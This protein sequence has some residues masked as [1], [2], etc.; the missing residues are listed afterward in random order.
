[1]I[2]T[3][4]AKLRTN[5]RRRVFRRCRSGQPDHR[6]QRAGGYG[7][8]ANA[9]KSRL[10]GLGSSTGVDLPVC[11]STDHNRREQK[12]PPIAARLLRNRRTRHYLRPARRR[13]RHGGWGCATH[14][15]LHALKPFKLADLGRLPA[16]VTNTSGLRRIEM[17]NHPL[18]KLAPHPKKWDDWRPNLPD[19]P[20]RSCVPF[21]FSLARLVAIPRT[22]GSTIGRP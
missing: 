9:D 4:A 10:R 20:C 18:E 13:L 3:A 12:P 16:L 17:T 21:A 5:Q 22:R 19:R 15:G 2:S 7:R 11:H 8:S 14:L 1:M 6:I